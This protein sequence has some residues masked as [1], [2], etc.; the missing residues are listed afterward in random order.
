M[1]DQFPQNLSK[2]Q[3]TFK[4]LVWDGSEQLP[5][6][7]PEYLKESAP[8]DW[9]TRVGIYQYA[10]KERIIES[11]EED[12]ETTKKAMGDKEFRSAMEAY[13]KVYPSQYASL[14]EVSKDVPAFLKEYSNTKAQP[15]LAELADMEWKLIKASLSENL[16]TNN[17]AELQNEENVGKDLIFILHNSVELVRYEYPVQD[18][19]EGTVKNI[20]KKPT[21]LVLFQRVKN[22]AYEEVEQS[23][24]L[25]L[26]EIKKARSLGEL[27]QFVTEN[28]IAPEKLGEYF[29]K[30]PS[31]GIIVAFKTV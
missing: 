4:K 17:L 19:F 26:S 24:W 25:L 9:K 29:S 3:T 28:N 12:F 8:I 1:I 23:E 22:G 6:V 7:S 20:S 2:L 14:A 15:Y 10:V 16:I 30:W 21:Y 11:L 18:F 31:L 27:N 13:L 5:K